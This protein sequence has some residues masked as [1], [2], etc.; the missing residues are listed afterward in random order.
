M[1]KGDLEAGYWKASDHVTLD[2][3][4]VGLDEEYDMTLCGYVGS[5]GF[6]S[7]NHFSSLVYGIPLT[8]FRVLEDQCNIIFFHYIF[9]S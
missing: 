3:L 8:T 7:I 5:S 4:V 2:F 1:E 9:E 6:I